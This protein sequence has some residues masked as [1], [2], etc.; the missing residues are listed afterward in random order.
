MTSSRR[1]A[2]IVAA[3]VVLAA[4]TQSSSTPTTSSAALSRVA[5]TDSE[6]TVTAM[7]R[8]GS[9]SVGDTTGEIRISPFP[10]QGDVPLANVHVNLCHPSASG[11]EYRVD[12]GDGTGP[13][14][15]GFCRFEHTYVK[16]GTFGM[17]VCVWDRSP[18]TAPGA[19]STFTVSTSAAA[20]PSTTSS[21]PLYCH[22]V[23]AVVWDGGTLTDIAQACP[24]GATQF[25]D[26]API[27]ATSSAQ[28]KLACEA[29]AGA[30]CVDFAG[31]G[32]H[33]SDPVYFFAPTC[34][35]TITTGDVSTGHCFAS[36][37]RWAP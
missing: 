31:I 29:C 26:S 15:G 30:P 3:V 24:S 10:V 35:G 1:V 14:R 28:A 17:T 32:W 33:S 23:S 27:I 36:V 8:A 34:G 2:A 11:L 16:A 18:A 4:C 37:T 20:P 7:A 5:T 19:C 9:W 12:W 21:S 25:C 6:G 13:E 22:A